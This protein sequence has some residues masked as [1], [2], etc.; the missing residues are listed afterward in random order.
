MG[1]RAVRENEKERPGRAGRH[2][3]RA[4]TGGTDRIEI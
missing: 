2:G 3:E 4:E 1:Q